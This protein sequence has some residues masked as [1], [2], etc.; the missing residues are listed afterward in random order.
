MRP[1]TITAAAARRSASSPP[2][3]I[4]RAPVQIELLELLHGAGANVDGLP[5][6]WQPL[7][8]ALAN[9]RP[10]A[11]RWLA[12]HGAR[13]TL[14]SA[15]GCGRLDLVQALADATADELYQGLVFAAEYGHADVVEHLLHRGAEIARPGRQ[16]PLHMAAHGGH[17]EIVKLLLARRAPLEITNEYGGTVLGQALWSAVHHTWDEANPTLDHAPIVNALVSAGAKVDPTWRTGIARID[18]LLRG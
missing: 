7:M 13:M 16:T 14:A 18:A 4:R 3:C 11:A 8:A 5:G 9:G 2:A 15:A 10:L 1:T 12:D 17:V 6:G